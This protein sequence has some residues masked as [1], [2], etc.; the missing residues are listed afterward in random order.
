MALYQVYFDTLDGEK[1]YNVDV[2]DEE[3]LEQVLR[4]VL[5]ELA[6]RGHMVR[7]VS[8]GDLKV[9]W[10]GTQG[11]ELDLA[12]P[13]PEQ[14]VHPNDVLRVLVETYEGGGRSL[15]NDRLDRE[16]ELLQRLARLNPGR[17][18][19]IGRVA[20]PPDDV[21]RVRLHDMPGV[22]RAEGATLT[23]RRV[24]TVQLRFPRFYP[25]TAIECYLDEPLFHPNV[26]ADTRFV[27]LWQDVSVQDG[28]VQAVARVAAMAA[29]RMVNMGAAHLMN[30]AAADWYC[31]V[32]LP[33]GLVPLP[34]GE[35]RVFDIDDGRFVW[36]EPARQIGRR[37]RL[38]LQ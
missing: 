33:T 23:V 5:A 26:R 3:P 35:V 4:D 19:V 17:L 14:D 15:R 22:E 34:A 6:E 9:V 28:V 16:W 12:R 32:A 25:E 38:R 31:T 24:H 7:G 10:G 20:T 2:G 29:F 30:R 36:L 13:L 37:P 8:T 18:D 11:R 27:C 21:F 1:K